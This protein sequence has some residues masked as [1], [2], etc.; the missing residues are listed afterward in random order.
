MNDIL[1]DKLHSQ[2]SQL[3]ETRAYVR[4]LEDAE[5]GR[6]GEIATILG[7]TGLAGSGELGEFSKCRSLLAC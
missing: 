7:G 5:E 2:S 1:R 4:E 3:E 6:L